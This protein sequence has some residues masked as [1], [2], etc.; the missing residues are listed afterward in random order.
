[1]VNIASGNL[2]N[3][4]KLVTDINCLLVKIDD[5]IL[6]FSKTNQITLKQNLF[7]VCDPTTIIDSESEIYTHAIFDS[8]VISNNNLVILDNSGDTISNSIDDMIYQENILD[9]SAI[10][11]NTIECEF[12]ITEICHQWQKRVV[13]NN[14][15][16]FF[17]SG[18]S[19]VTTVESC[20]ITRRYLEVDAY[21]TDFTY[22]SV[23]M[24][25][26]GQVLV[27]D[28]TNTITILR[29]EMYYPTGKMP[30]NLY[31]Y[32]D[33]SKTYTDSNP[34]GEG[35][36]WN[37]ECPLTVET[38]DKM[39]W[40]AFDGR[41]IR[42]KTSEEDLNEWYDENGEG[43][44][45]NINASN[46][47]N[48][49]YNGVTIES[50]NGLTYTFGV[51][52]K[53][54]RIDDGNSNYIAVY[55]NNETTQDYIVSIENNSGYGYLFGYEE[56]YGDKL[57][58]TQI[59]YQKKSDNETYN[60][61][62]IDGVNIIMKYEYILLPDGNIALSKVMY[63][64]D[65][66]DDQLTVEYHY[67][68]NGRLTDVFDTDK[69]KLTLIYSGDV[70]DY[71]KRAIAKLEE[72]EEDYNATKEV[73]NYPS[74]FSLTEKVLNKEC[75]SD[76]EGSERY[77]EKSSLAI[78]RHLTYQRT[79]TDNF[80]KAETIHYNHNF[81][82]LYYTNDNKDNY[83]VDYATSGDRHY[84]SQIISPENKESLNTQPG[85]ENGRNNQKPTGWSEFGGTNI[86]KGITGDLNGNGNRIA[87][88]EGS[89]N[90]ERAA[91]Q[92]I[93]I[94]EAEVGD[95]IVIGCDARASAAVPNESHFF[96]IEIYEATTDNSGYKSPTDNLLYRLHF[97][98]TMENESQRRLGAFK[99]TE[100]ID[101]IQFRLVY[102][103][104]TGY[105]YFDNALTYIA[106]ENNVSFFDEPSEEN[107][108]NDSSSS[109][110]NENDDDDILSDGVNQIGTLYDYSNETNYLMGTTDSNDVTTNFSYDEYT[111][112]LKQKS[113]EMGDNSST[114]VDEYS[115]DAMGALTE[116]ARVVGFTENADGEKTAIK[117]TTN[118]EYEYGKI[119][120]VVHNNMIYKF[121]YD[122]Y[123]ALK[124]IIV[125]PDEI[126]EE[127]G[128]LDI[129]AVS[130]DYSTDTHRNINK[131]TYSN[132]YVLEYTYDENGKITSISEHSD[133]SL[134]PVTLYEYIYDET[135]GDLCKIKDCVSSRVMIYSDDSFEIYE[136]VG[137][138][139]T[140]SDDKLLYSKKPVAT[141][142]DTGTGTNID[143]ETIKVFSVEYNTQSN[144]PTYN[145]E[146]KIT[147]YSS[148]TTTDIS[149]PVKI[150]SQAAC[151]Y[152]GRIKN[153]SVVIS[154]Q[155]NEDS[156][157]KHSIENE[158][159]YLNNTDG[160]LTTNLLGTYSSTMWNGAAET[161]TVLNEFTSEYSYDKAG[162]ITH[163]YYKQNDN[164]RELK[165]YYNYD[166]AGQLVKEADFSEMTYTEYVYDNFGNVIK[167]T[168]YSGD[169][170]FVYE[171]DTVS[172]VS[173]ST[174]EIIE[175]GYNPNYRDVLERYDGDFISH[176]EYGNPL[177]YHGNNQGTP[178]TYE[179][180][181]EGN[182]LRSAKP[183][184]ND[185]FYEYKYDDEGRRTQKILYS[186]Y[187]PE[188]PET[189]T[190]DMIMDYIWD[191]NRLVGYRC[192]LGDLDCPVTIDAA[193]LYDELDDPI[194]LRFCANGLT[195]SENDADLS[196]EDVFWFVKDGQGNVVAIYSEISDYMIG[197]TKTADGKIE[198]SDFG[199]FKS[200]L[201]QKIEEAD[202][203]QS[204]LL[205]ALSAILA[206]RAS[207][208]LSTDASQAT[209]ISAIMDEET[210]LYYCQNRY[211]SPEYGRF[212]NIG[213]AE[214]IASD[215][216]NPFNSNP[217]VYYNNDPISCKGTVSSK[218]PATK[219]VGI[220]A[221]LSKSLTSFTDSTGVELIY[222]SVKDELYAYYYQDASSYSNYKGMPRAIEMITDIFKNVSF[223]SDISLKNLALVFKLNNYVSLSYF[224]AETNKRFI[225]P[226][227][228][229]GVAKV[230]PNGNNRY[231]V[232]GSGYQSKGICYY[233][234]SN[235]GFGTK[236]MSV[237]YKKIEL[238]SSAIKTYLSTNKD[239][240]IEAVK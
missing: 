36:H 151:D 26:A 70:P 188:E 180:T 14:G 182:L 149:Y 208:M 130:Y 42:F 155:N 81:E 211:Y 218:K 234:V 115:Y 105:A 158:S 190:V 199:N 166:I 19:S 119:S 195:D 222:D 3:D 117:N 92:Y 22:H 168:I 124:D 173:G 55:Y 179:L 38:Q 220:Q 121:N 33:F 137:N 203:F 232:Y 15:L 171:N 163:I 63:P 127:A 83:Y 196:S 144:S 89:I 37:Y 129:T 76:I 174:P 128:V 94:N 98:S 157:I 60:N 21:D 90:A 192:R 143:T 122:S 5:S 79:F 54:I 152:F 181:W 12:D 85:F 34:A 225:W 147:T 47:T 215:I 29:N 112:F 184:N 11:A 233:P 93:S 207:M 84:V 156:V 59:Q 178:T 135:S 183:E 240:I 58:L 18:D 228:Y 32:F 229:L 80:G 205:I 136:L 31:R 167:K 2:S 148:S 96:G 23:D 187:N 104:Q 65:N 227:S 7:I 201:N 108:N 87:Q 126:D 57:A 161:G 49:T 212:I 113:A 91:T 67:D 132:G 123:G 185:S 159:T 97:D 213:N 35:S 223:S 16:I 51:A 200:E 116:V 64:S 221:E 230:E 103:Y 141:E 165:Y 4:R 235:L 176:D 43:Y 131:I 140:V 160:T 145:S 107:D 153:S 237:R 224:N 194:G 110:S 28:F 177:T 198:I 209:Y 69:R 162:R 154:E 99:L 118:Y 53:L 238:D 175:I 30:I 39:A 6:S 73:D 68:E 75:S 20:Y 189:A 8:W 134:E 66:P 88:I 52:G 78:E 77:L 82:L 210:G 219:V 111:G 217:F 72:N 44:T 150:D 17:I 191:S 204:G 100:D 109:S 206:I 10:N 120:T 172:P 62:S 56:I 41:T 169:G 216:Y 193:I 61:V 164:D 27:N 202:D 138:G 45:L 231:T 142:T 24:G 133:P 226:T 86:L 197:C 106:S 46:I 170:S 74:I 125:E 114:M 186:D 13:N 50:P 1:M 214:E 101:W 25:K 139:D 48:E 71:A 95:I 236:D 102:S 9:S 146:S 239:N 40:S